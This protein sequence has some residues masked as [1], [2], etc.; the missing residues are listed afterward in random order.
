MKFIV[1]RSSDIIRDMFVSNRLPC[2]GA[3]LEAITSYDHSALPFSVIVDAGLWVIELPTYADLLAF[4][5]THG[6]CV[7]HSKGQNEYHT[8]EIY[9]DW[10]E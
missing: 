6:K 7:I 5:D 10:R 8:I 3:Q 2:N 1:L 9:D 4:I